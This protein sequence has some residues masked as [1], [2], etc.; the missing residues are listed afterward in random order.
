MIRRPPRSTRTDTLFPST[1]LFRSHALTLTRTHLYVHS[2]ACTH[3]YALTCAT[4]RDPL[5][6]PQVPSADEWPDES[7]DVRAPIATRIGRLTDTLPARPRRIGVRRSVNSTFDV[8]FN[9]SP[10]E[11]AIVPLSSLGREIG[12]AHV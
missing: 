11:G 1:T 5:V 3:L 10:D 6:T 8:Y 4:P 12:R 7:D 9:W 2:C